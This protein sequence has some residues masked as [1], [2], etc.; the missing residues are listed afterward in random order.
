MKKLISVV[1]VLV[2]MFSLS[3][4]A[5][6]TSN[7]ESLPVSVE[8]HGEIVP[9]STLSFS[10]SYLRAGNMILSDET[11]YIKDENGTLTIESC[12]WDPS[13][14]DVYIGWYNAETGKLY[15][16]TYSDGEIAN[17]KINSSG[18]PDGDYNVCVMNAGTKSI[19]G[20]IKYKVR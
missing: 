16:V 11:Y 18:I 4:S 19:S 1:L 20:A 2:L 8:Q 13:S 7:T 12:T 10:F 5:F 9:F 14:Q 3:C 15:S 17:K 6:A